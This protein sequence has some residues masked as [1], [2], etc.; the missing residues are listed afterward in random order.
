MR[1]IITHINVESLFTTN[2][3]IRKAGFASHKDVPIHYRELGLKVIRRIKTV[4]IEKQ[5]TL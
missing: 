3:K 4:K 5:Y 2:F 1:D